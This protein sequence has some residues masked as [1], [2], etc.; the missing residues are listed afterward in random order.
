MQGIVYLVGAGP[1]DPG[2]I[3]VKG[4]ACIEQAEVVIY[5]YLASA[6]LLKHASPDAELIYVGKKGGDHTLSQDGINALIVGK[7]LEGKV[8]TRLKGGDPF[9]F[10]RGG[11]EAQALIDAGLPF[12][13]VPGVTSAIAAPAYAGIPLTHRQ[14]TSTVAFITGHED[15]NKAESSIDWRALAQ[16]IGTLVFFMGVKNLPRIVDQLIKHGLPPDKPVALVRWG[17]T[18]RQ[19]AVAGTLADIV[20]RVNQAGLK[21]PAIIVVGDVVDL[22]TQMQWFEKRPLMGKRIVVTRA[23]EQASDLVARLTALGAECLE[24]PTIKIAPPEDWTPLDRALDNL[25]TYDWLVFTSVNGV[26]F[27]FKRLFALGQDVRA[28]GH[29]RTGAIGP[30]TADHLAAFGLKSDILPD[31][32]RAEGV[33]AAFEKETLAGCRV[34]LPRA[35]EARSVLPVELVRMGAE[36]DEIAVYHTLPVAENSDQL[37]L[38]LQKGQVDLI[39]FTSSSTVK[40]FNALIPED[41]RQALLQGVTLASI[42]PITTS[43]AAKLGYKIDLTADT[44]T[45]PGLCQEILKYYQDN[46][47]S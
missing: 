7:A 44:Y 31:N 23:R 41:D 32:Y 22:R 5:D 47:T 25:S 21:A 39:T 4:Q 17:T 8:V 15:P 12:E 46:T 35:R 6:H 24:F 13:V 3:T 45:I 33:V 43:T 14:Y 26:E 18:P 29:L 42:G 10:G 20:D 38:L 11:E 40:N 34:L 36:V 37:L 30:A 19:T 9:I 1:G 27:F 16:G 2:L 28:L